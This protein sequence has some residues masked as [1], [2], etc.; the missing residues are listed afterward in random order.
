MTTLA[1]TRTGTPSAA[2]GYLGGT[3]TVL[4]W[5]SWIL[6]TRH[7]AAT[8]LGTIDIGLIRYG[9]P[10]IVLAPVWWRIGPLPKGVSPVSRRK[11]VAPSAHRSVR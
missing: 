4:I 2:T 3:V 11:T 5:A 9:V 6:A 1:F 7:S 10:A 8:P